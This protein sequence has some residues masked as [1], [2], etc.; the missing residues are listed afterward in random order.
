MP[1]NKVINLVDVKCLRG[2]KFGIEALRFSP[3]ISMLVSLG[4]QND[5][6]L[7]I[8]NWREGVKIS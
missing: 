3:D 6:G 4:S 7:F 5:K 1:N 8:W 2:H